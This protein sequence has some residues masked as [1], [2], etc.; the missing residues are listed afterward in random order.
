V[1]TYP[2]EV[3]R[4]RQETED[5]AT[6]WF[7]VPV[8]LT[9]AFSYRTGQFLSVVEDLDGETVTRQYSL[10]SVP[11]VD[12]QLRIT[13]KRIPG[14]RMS[15]W[16]VDKVGEGDILEVERPRGRFYVPSQE[17][18]HH[19]L[20]AAGSGI[21]PLYA[22]ARH[23][24]HQR[25]SSGVDHRATLMYGNR[26]YGSIIMRE[27]VDALT[28]LDVD[29]RHVLSRPPQGWVG[30]VGHV[31][32][33]YLESCWEALVGGGPALMVYLCGP[34]GF[35]AAAE[36]WFLDHGAPIDDIRKESFDL[37]LNDDVGEPDLLVPPEQDG[38]ADEC[39]LLTAAIGGREIEV[40]PE[41]GE[42]LLSALLR[43]TDD[44]PFSCQ[45]GTCSSCIVRL[46]E[47]GVGLRP[48]VLQTLRPA[49]LDEG[50][51]LACLATARTRR[52]RIDFDNI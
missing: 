41:P 35:M 4:R 25:D 48:Q 15:T 8:D 52:V 30:A 46:T 40:T 11:G 5:T 23:L 26:S 19:L 36:S 3:A 16:L 37:V 27:E 51:V 33:E 50:L 20:L 34:E 10:A 22:I 18:R 2:L 6:F 12:R 47:G 21:V 44:V 43:V 24:A 38:D 49:D 9:T 7:D 39:S 32:A 1:T 42:R 13:V 28:R 29:V 45:E 14:G 17:P 31:D